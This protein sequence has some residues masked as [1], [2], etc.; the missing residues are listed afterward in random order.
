MSEM[1]R[2]GGRLTVVATPIGNLGDL[3][4]RA[5]RVLAEADVILCEDTRHTRGLLSARGI[6]ASGRLVALHQHNEAS[7]VDEVVRRVLAGEHVAL[8]SDAGTPGISDPGSRVVMAVADAGGVVSTIPGPSA[9]VAAL[10]VSG[11]E[12]ER[13]VMEGF[14]PRRAGERRARFDE[15]V[16]ESRTIVFYE[17]PQRIAETMAELADRCGDRRVALVRELTKMYEE[18][19]RGTVAELAESLRDRTTLGEVVVVLEGARETHIDTS[20][21]EGTL[22]DLLKSGRSV[23]D[24]VNELSHDVGVPH[25]ELYQ[26]ALTLRDQ[27]E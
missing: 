3:S 23:R 24:A 4:P 12:T 26:L 10:S 7:Q 8:V 14:V 21:L 5:E 22:R 17:S 27:E 18:V 9:V 6:R 13:F 2:V 16:R 1:E 15:W 11:L 25:R 19:R 20:S